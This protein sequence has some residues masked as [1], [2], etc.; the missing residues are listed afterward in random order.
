V[1][2]PSRRRTARDRRAREVAE[3]RAELCVRARGIGAG[4]ALLELLDVEPPGNSVLAQLA[5]G[6][7]AL[8]VGRAQRRIQRR[9]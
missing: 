8:V 1:R 3:Q 7:L 9:R 5:H 6:G 4:D 2:W